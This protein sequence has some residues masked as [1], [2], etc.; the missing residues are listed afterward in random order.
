MA[1]YLRTDINRA[2]RAAT[3]VT[4]VWPKGAHRGMIE[5]PLFGDR[6]VPHTAPAVRA[7][8]TSNVPTGEFPDG[9]PDQVAAALGDSYLT[10]GANVHG[11]NYD[12]AGD[13]NE[14]ARL[15]AA[16]QGVCAECRR[17]LTDP[18]SANRGYGPECW[19]LVKH[20]YTEAP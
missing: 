2:A 6:A 12:N 4:P 10:Q 5:H 17:P 15:L 19:E 3:G 7:W 8:I 18:L 20:R 9:L 13:A 1:Y 11:V 14:A 16:S